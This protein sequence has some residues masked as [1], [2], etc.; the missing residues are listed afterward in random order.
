MY[1][2]LCASK[3]LVYNVARR[4]GSGINSMDCASAILYSSENAVKVS[5]EAIQCLGL[6]SIYC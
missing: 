3:S 6:Y 5:L 4:L 1:T 2:L